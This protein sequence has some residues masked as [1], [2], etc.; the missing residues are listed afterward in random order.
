MVNRLVALVSVG[1][2][3][4]LL[5]GLR[6][7]PLP[8]E[9]VCGRAY[10]RPPTIEAD[11]IGPLKLQA[12]LVDLKRS[13]IGARDTSS[14]VLDRGFYVLA[15]GSRIEVLGDQPV[16]GDPADRVVSVIRVSGGNRMRT[17]EGIGPGS[18][19]RDA[20]RAWGDLQVTGCAAGASY[21]YVVGRPGLGL[22][23]KSRCPTADREVS[24]YPDSLVIDAVEIFVP[25]D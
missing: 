7:F 11:S 8:T 5:S 22:S 14:S 15:F 2:P 18:K 4:A 12:S 25:V 9:T 16:L 19:I 6:P 20:K 24:A 23:L 1:A 21:A 3:V 10:H 17:P 13:C